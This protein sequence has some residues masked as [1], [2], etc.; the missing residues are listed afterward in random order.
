MITDRENTF[1]DNLLPGATA[2]PFGDVVKITNRQYVPGLFAYVQAETA[3]NNA[4]SIRLELLASAAAD[5]SSPVVLYDT[6]VVA[7]A[8]FNAA[9]R[10]VTALP[11]AGQIR[12]TDQYIGWRLTVAGTAP[13]IGGLTASIA[14]EA[15]LES[16][17]RPAYW[18]GL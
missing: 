5:L 15:T 14:E 18:T 13:T 4:T 11:G 12:Q 9:Q 2:T 10:Y 16:L 8:A 3:V 17:P 1:F 7:L 6:G